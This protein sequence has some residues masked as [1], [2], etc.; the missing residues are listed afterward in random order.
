MVDQ[1]QNSEQQARHWFEENAEAI[2]AQGE[3]IRNHGIPGSKLALN[4]PRTDPLES[5]RCS[6]D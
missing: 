3:L 5:K 1:K 2:E 6:N 4:Y